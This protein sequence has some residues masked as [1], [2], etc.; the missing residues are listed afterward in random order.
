MEWERKFPL[1]PIKLCQIPSCKN[2]EGY[3]TG[4]YEK[5]YTP[6]GDVC[7]WERNAFTIQNHQSA[8]SFSCQEAPQWNI[9]CI[10]QRL[11]NVCTAQLLHSHK[12]SNSMS[13]LT[14]K[15]VFPPHLF[16]YKTIYHLIKIQG[17]SPGLKVVDRLQDDNSYYPL[18]ANMGVSFLE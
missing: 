3:M 12:H 17:Q 2:P 9:K 4:V 5:L 8:T 6:V 10:K 15:Q 14:V 18:W 16:L 1:F 13:C 7:L 11:T